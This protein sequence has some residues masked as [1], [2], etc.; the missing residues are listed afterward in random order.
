MDQ[1]VVANQ[2]LYWVYHSQEVGKCWGSLWTHI[3]FYQKLP[4]QPPHDFITMSIHNLDWWLEMDVQGKDAPP[5]IWQMNGPCQP[6]ARLY[7]TPLPNCLSQ[8]GN[9]QGLQTSIACAMQSLVYRLHYSELAWLS[10]LCTSEARSLS[11]STRLDCFLPISICTS[12]SPSVVETLF[13]MYHVCEVAVRENCS[14]IVLSLLQSHQLTKPQ[15][16]G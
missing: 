11:T 7:C 8:K 1:Q 3:S 15:T 16:M 9:W 6:I 12:C 10:S 2:C 4:G 5:A 13:A 14:K